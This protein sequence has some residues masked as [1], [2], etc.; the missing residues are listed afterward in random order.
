METLTLN[1]ADNYTR[2]K[3]SD[4]AFGEKCPRTANSKVFDFARRQSQKRP[5]GFGC[6]SSAL[7]KA[8]PLDE[9]KK[10]RAERILLL[11]VAGRIE[12]DLEWGDAGGLGVTVHEEALAVLGD[13]VSE[14]IGR[15]DLRAAVTLE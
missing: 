15:G 6:D 3:A 13:V 7:D 11:R 1:V 12:D 10:H 4:S 2:G 8:H 9:E 14:E 5:H